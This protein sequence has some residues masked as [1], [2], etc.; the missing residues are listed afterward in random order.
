[1]TVV[2]VAALVLPTMAQSYGS[3]RSNDRQPSATAP[4]AGFRTTSTMQGSGSTY[5]SNPTLESNGTAS[6]PASGPNKA[7]K[8]V[9][10]IS[11]SDVMEQ[12]IH[13]GYFKEED[14]LDTPLGD[15]VLPLALMALAFGGVAVRRRRSAEKN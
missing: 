13:E 3:Q 1:M 8:A 15:A 4:A 10:P 5:T 7:K 6:A 9:D 12:Y 14:I 11:G 2:M